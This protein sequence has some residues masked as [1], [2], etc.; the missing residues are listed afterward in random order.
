MWT[1]VLDTGGV[2]LDTL[3]GV[4]A[5]GESETAEFRNVPAHEDTQQSM[6]RV[7]IT[8]A[9]TKGGVILV[10]IDHQRA[11]TGTTGDATEQLLKE[12]AARRTR[13]PV[14]IMVRQANLEGKVVCMVDVPADSG[15][16]HVPVSNHIP[17][18]RVGKS[19]RI[20]PTWKR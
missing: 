2:G 1:P 6:A 8:F 11:V 19:E 5:A 10:G 7:M 4:L 12:I 14:S 18:I 17:Y 9:N 3:R 13:P 16:R 15:Q 20:D